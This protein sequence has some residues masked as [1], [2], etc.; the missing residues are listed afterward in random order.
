M[1]SLISLVALLCTAASLSAQALSTHPIA[2]PSNLTTV[3]RA[4]VFAGRT[5]RS[6]PAGVHIS[7]P[8]A[9]AAEGPGSRANL[10]IAPIW[11]PRGMGAR[12]GWSGR[13][14]SSVVTNADLLPQA[15]TT[16]DGS[17]R[18]SP[19][20]YRLVLTAGDVRRGTLV[21]EFKGIRVNR[22]FAEAIV[23]IGDRS[24][25]FAAT[26]D[27]NSNRMVIE[28][29]KTGHYGLPVTITLSGLAH[30]SSAPG[31]FEAALSLT[32]KADPPPPQVCKVEP[33]RRG[34]PAGGVLTGR[35]LSVHT[36]AF[37]RSRN[38]IVLRLQ[39]ALP[40]AI[41]VTILSRNGEVGRFPLTDCPILLHPIVVGVSNTDAHGNALNSIR[42]PLVSGNLQFFIQQVTVKFGGD[43]GFQIASSN[44]L[45]VKCSH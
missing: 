42:V 35:V 9:L 20:T 29:L 8:V 4:G 44:T 32:F 41:V 19:Q 27:G 34:C 3:T 18:F 1:R 22:A 10:E 5:V 24:L 39:R 37:D 12:F 13:A 43:A 30:G 36:A 33:D 31:G 26:A 14:D 25:D 15:G 11:E 7:H 21:I 16:G 40:N 45:E 38:H 17:P 23:A 2:A 6:L 28:G